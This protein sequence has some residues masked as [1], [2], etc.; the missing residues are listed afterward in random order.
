MAPLHCCCYC[1]FRFGSIS[2]SYSLNGRHKQSHIAVLVQGAKDRRA[3]AGVPNWFPLCLFPSFGGTLKSCRRGR[4]KEQIPGLRRRRWIIFG[5]IPNTDSSPTDHR[6]LA[7][8]TRGAGMGGSLSRAT[9]GTN[10]KDVFGWRLFCSWCSISRVTVK[11][12]LRTIEPKKEKVYI[13][14]S[15]TIWRFILC[16]S[17]LFG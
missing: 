4:R 3:V 13:L 15:W 17:N 14:S 9:N 10:S 6:K 5:Q 12:C 8:D 16:V 1:S 7:A 11:W 2:D